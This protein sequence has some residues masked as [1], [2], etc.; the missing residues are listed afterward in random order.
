MPYL[1]GIDQ[2]FTPLSLNGLDAFTSSVQDNALLLDGSNAM[3]ADLNA[4]GHSVKNIN[5]AVTSDEAVNLGQLTT[6]LGNYVDRT[7]AQSV[8]GVKTFTDQV[9]LSSGATC[10]SQ[11]IQNVANPT[12]AQDAATK[13]YVDTQDALRVAK[14]GDAMTGN[15]SMGANFVTCTSNPTLSDQLTRKGYVDTVVNDF[16]AV[17]VSKSGD[18]MTGN[19]SM[20]ANFVTCTSNPTLFDQL[21]RKGYVDTVVNDFAAVKVSKSGDSMTGNLSMGSNFVTCTSNPTLF[22]QLTRK[23][24]VDTVVNDFAAVKV[25]KSGDSMTGQLSMGSNKIVSL[26]NGTAA[27]DAATFGQLTGAI[28]VPAVQ[29]VTT[30]TFSITDATPLTTMLFFDGGTVSLPTNLTPGKILQFVHNYNTSNAISLWSGLG[31]GFINGVGGAQQTIKLQFCHSVTL[32]AQP[33]GWY[34]ILSINQL[35]PHSRVMN[36]YGSNAMGIWTWDG[37]TLNSSAKRME[38][39]HTAVSTTVP[40]SPGAWSSGQLIATKIYNQV[41]SGTGVL[42]VAN[43]VTSTWK[44]LTYTCLNSPSSSLLVVEVW[45]PFAMEGNAA[46]ETFVIVEDT[47]GTAQ[48]IV[49]NGQ[50]WNNASG[51]GTR[52]GAMLPVTGSYAP[53]QATGTNARTIRIQFDNNSGDDDL[54]ICKMYENA[55]LVDQDTWTVRVTEYKA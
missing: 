50:R 37:N 41:S 42:T 16:A 54:Y 49:K 48:Q 14:S 36:D 7:S 31:G 12:A 4:G 55:A 19:L 47:T 23:W 15:L 2:Y 10:N 35:A 11:R 21:T 32:L 25:S 1:S 52:S 38:I 40:L 9:V 45:A 22:D 51:G 13:S 20:G 53:S 17:K 44:T 39:S 26:A 43:G 34:F 27:S 24:Y 33:S 46:D 6:S 8:A 28:N 3:L 29:Q 30:S 18:S 5:A